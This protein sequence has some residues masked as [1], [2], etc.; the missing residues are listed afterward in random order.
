M[1]KNCR[2]NKKINW[3]KLIS[4][5]AGKVVILFA[6]VFFVFYVGKLIGIIPTLLI[7]VIFAWLINRSK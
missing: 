1:A 7:L 2:S 5:T 4:T 3:K 6:L